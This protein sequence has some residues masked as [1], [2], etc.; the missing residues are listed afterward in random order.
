MALPF[1]PPKSSK[2]VPKG[3]TV[4]SALSLRDHDWSTSINIGRPTLG[5]IVSP[6]PDWDWPSD[7]LYVYFFK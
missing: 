3:I 7:G 5:Q 4:H 1:N 2:T 6:S